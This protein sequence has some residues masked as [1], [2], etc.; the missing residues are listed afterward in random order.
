MVHSP[1]EIEASI[2]TLATDPDAGLIVIPDGFAQT[3]RKLIIELTAHYSLPAVYPFRFFP[4]NGGLVSY[5][6]EP[7]GVFRQF[8]YVPIADI[9]PFNGFGRMQ[10]PIFG[11]A[12]GLWMN[13]ARLILGVSSVSISSHFAPIVFSKLANPVTLPPGCGRLVTNPLPTGSP[14][15][16]NT[17][18]MARVSCRRISVTWLVLGT[19]TSELHSDQLL[20]EG[21]RPVGIA[22][23]PT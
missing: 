3:H 17:I 8:R 13:P 1:A 19:I 23:S 10:E 6:V 2:K 22:A 9:P 21:A 4:T 5:G 15:N 16:T 11:A 12:S 18:G 14:T 7:H 20:R